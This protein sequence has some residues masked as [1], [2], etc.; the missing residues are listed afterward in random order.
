MVWLQLPY[1]TNSYKF[2]LSLPPSNVNL[3]GISS[4]RRFKAVHVVWPTAALLL[5]MVPW[6]MTTLWCWWC[7]LVGWDFLD[8]PRKKLP[9][10]TSKKWGIIQPPMMP[11][12]GCHGGAIQCHCLMKKPTWWNPSP[13]KNRQSQKE[14]H[15]PTI[16]FQG[17]FC[18]LKDAGPTKKT[19]WKQTI[20]E[21]FQGPSERIQSTGTPKG[22][23]DRGSYRVNLLG[24]LKLVGNGWWW[25]WWWWW[26]WRR[27]WWWWWWWWWWCL[28]TTK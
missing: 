7:W 1:D 4:F 18:C 27:R 9:T 5:P 28:L 2:I 3:G 10:A 8:V 14:A 16:I 22:R 12:L 26:W 17:L 23:L 11:W 21:S 24:G 13:P 20:S 19:C 6:K 15:L 25:W